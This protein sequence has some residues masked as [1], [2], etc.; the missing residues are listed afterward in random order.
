[1]SLPLISR[2]PDLARLKADGY[3]VEIRAGHLILNNVPYVNGDRQV[4]RGRLVSE[5]TTAGELAAKPSTHVAMLAG[6]YPC[7]QYG[8]PIEKIRNSSVQQDL[9]EGL[10]I[11]HSF[12]SKPSPEGYADYYDKMTTYAAILSS[13]A[14]A[15]DPSANAQTHAVIEMAET[16]DVFVYFDS[17]TSRAGIGALTQRFDGMKIAIVGLGG[18]GAYLLDLIAKTPVAEVHLFD[19]DRFLTHN[20][21]RAPGAASLDE[22]TACPLKVDYWTEKYA[23]MRRGIVPHPIRL[24]ASNTELLA[25]MHFVF[26][27]IDDGAAKKPIVAKLEALGLPFIDAGIGVRVVNDQLLGLVRVTASTANF[28]RHVYDAQRISFAE[29]D[30]QALYTNNIQ[31]ADLNA[32]NACLVVIKWK[33]LVGFYVDLER[34]LFSTYEIDGNNIINEDLT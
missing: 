4:K 33:K 3:E 19:G 31:I 9:G 32:L 24:D 26:L 28:R 2:S 10:V 25:D 1:M 29:R 30:R 5:L 13:P 22:L 12:S 7:D 23:K 16:D 15:L 27:C 21:F 14:Q 34:E 17:N 8:N 6:E 18:T 11:D 20:A